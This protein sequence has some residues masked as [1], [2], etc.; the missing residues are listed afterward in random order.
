MDLSENIARQAA[1]LFAHLPADEV[2]DDEELLFTLDQ[3]GTLAV[4]VPRTSWNY[5]MRGGLVYRYQQRPDGMVQ[6]AAFQDGKVLKHYSVNLEEARCKNAQ[7]A[8]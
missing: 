1:E 6:V 4:F 2:D 3:E 7:R 8:D 5:T